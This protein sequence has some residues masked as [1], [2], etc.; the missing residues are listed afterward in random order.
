[1]Q[2]NFMPTELMNVPESCAE[3]NAAVLYKGHNTVTR[4]IRNI[5]GH[6]FTIIA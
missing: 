5:A 6:L 1:M 2:T 3:F 4:M